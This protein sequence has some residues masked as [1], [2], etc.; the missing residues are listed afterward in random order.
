MMR[1]DF[2]AMRRTLGKPLARRVGLA[3]GVVIAGAVGLL[4]VPSLSGNV[5]M[6]DR[7]A[8]CTG[9]VAVGDTM[10]SPATGGD[11]DFFEVPSTPPSA[12]FLVG[13]N[14]SM[15]EFPEFLPEVGNTSVFGCEDPALVAA[16]S[17]FDKDSADVTKNGSVVYD[18][19]ADFGATPQFFNPTMWYQSRGRRI[20]WV[21]EDFP[22]SMHTDFRAMD[23]NDNTWSACNRALNWSEPWGSPVIAKC[24]ACLASK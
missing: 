22:F 8:C 9:A 12:I 4:A 3:A 18:S 14:E 23:G 2:D 21:V 19:D 6:P 16:M 17:W 5:P 24:E 11:K 20:G 10:I 7:A 1:I 15:Q 13:N